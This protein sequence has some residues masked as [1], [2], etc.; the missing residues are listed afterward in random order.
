MNKTLHS[1]LIAL[2][3]F[4]PAPFAL[5]GQEAPKGIMIIDF[6]APWCGPCRT[7]MPIMQKLH[8]NGYPVLKINTDEHPDLAQKYDVQSIPALFVLKSD[9][10]VTRI[11][12]R[13]YNALARAIDKN[14]VAKNLDA[15]RR[16]AET[17]NIADF[18]IPAQYASAPV[19]ASTSGP[20]GVNNPDAAFTESYICTLVG[21][22]LPRYYQCVNSNDPS[23]V[24][25]V[26][27]DKHKPFF[28]AIAA[29]K[30][31]ETLKRN[32][33]DGWWRII[34]EKITPPAAAS[35]PQ[36]PVTPPPQPA[37]GEPVIAA[38]GRGYIVT[39]PG[40]YP[41]EVTGREIDDFISRS[42]GAGALIPTRKAIAVLLASSKQGGPLPAPPSNGAPAI[43]PEP[44]APSAPSKYKYTFG[45]ITPVESGG[46]DVI[47]KSRCLL[48]ADGNEV[49]CRP[50][51]RTV[52]V[53][54]ATNAEEAKAA[55]IAFI[56]KTEVPP[57]VPP[58]K[59]SLPRPGADI[60]RVPTPEEI[61]A[62]EERLRDVKQKRMELER[63]LDA[64]EKS[65]SVPPR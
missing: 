8:D 61:E 63:R 41:V 44:P 20:Y 13:D 24:F 47:I 32:P 45:K 23:A 38:N 11:S 14:A 22:R 26:Y 55:A 59:S 57:A 43:P 6:H 9:G 50:W 1:I 5:F 46:Y 56:D 16:T 35:N 51:Q 28:D 62:L 4:A 2:A 17:F 25:I 31:N 18:K 7:L 37:P 36:A 54:G 33:K 19:A 12:G 15:L 53:P 48:D 3:L 60:N 34:P 27:E 58:K 52:R 30:P 49:D 10:A 65:G 21:S 39:F 64:L 42:S 29:M 40:R